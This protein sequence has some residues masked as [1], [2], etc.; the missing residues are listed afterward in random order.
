MNVPAGRTDGTLAIVFGRNA[1]FDRMATA[2]TEP[3]AVRK[4]HPTSVS[5]G[6][7]RR[8]MSEHVETSPL[9]LLIPDWPAPARVS[10]CMSTRT[11]GISLPPW[12]SLNL[13]DHVGD[14]PAHVAHNR[15]RFES[16]LPAS[17]QGEL[18]YLRQVHGT[19]VARVDEASIGPVEA[20]AATSMSPGRV[21]LIGVAD[22]LPVL[23]T[24][25]D[26]TAVGAAHAGWRGLCAGVLEATLSDLCLRAQCSARDVLAWLGPCIGA[27]AFEVGAEVLARFD[28]PG[29]AARF[30]PSLAPDGS[31]R[32][33]ADL[34]GLARLRLTQ[35]GVLSLHGNDSNPDWCTVTQSDRF[36]S[37]R[38]A[39]RQG[40]AGTGR[41]AAAIWIKRGMH[42]MDNQQDS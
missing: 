32:W 14:D 24:T 36:F 3:D 17:M 20:D 8:T 35:A 9:G 27:D 12:D 2:S 39:T 37:H 38:R 23:F 6:T 7:L 26:G 19:R 22:C 11:G 13:G 29:E 10:A 42:P 40:L 34:A 1:M 25:R 41:M 16:C 5:G 15:H 28:R 21:C 31:P 33:L 4:R 30:R 18:L